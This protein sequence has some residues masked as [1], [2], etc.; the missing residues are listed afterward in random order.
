MKRLGLACALALLATTAHAECYGSET[1]QTCTDGS[2]NTYN[3]TRFGNVTT[4]QGYNSNTGSQWSQNTYDY[5]NLTMHN[6][7]DADGNSWNMNQQSL[8]GQTF[9]NGIDSSG[10]SFSGLCGPLGCY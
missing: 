3:V 4:M 5:G 7:I 8:G 9:F 2:G 6:G 1:F 10:Q